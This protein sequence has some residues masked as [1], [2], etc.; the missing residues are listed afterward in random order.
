MR[1]HLRPNSP[2][3]QGSPAAARPTLVAAGCELAEGMAVGEGAQDQALLGGEEL[4][5]HKVDRCDAGAR[6]R[7]DLVDEGVQGGEV[8]QDPVLAVEEGEGVLHVGDALANLPD[9]LDGDRLRDLL[10]GGGELAGLGVEGEDVVAGAGLAGGEGGLQLRRPLQP[11]RE[12]AVRPVEVDPLD[13]RL[14]GDGEAAGGEEGGGDSL[15]DG[16]DGTA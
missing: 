1:Y 10:L 4:V 6:L 3:C 15:G 11:L 14:G 9:G 7:V 5:D 13:D 2:L 12:L 16:V 8:G